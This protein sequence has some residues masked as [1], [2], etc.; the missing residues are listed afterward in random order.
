M[1][2]DGLHCFDEKKCKL[3]DM[4]RWDEFAICYPC[5][6]QLIVMITCGVAGMMVTSVW[7]P[8]LVAASILH[9]LHRPL[10]QLEACGN[11][12]DVQRLIHADLRFEKIAAATQQAKPA[13]PP[14]P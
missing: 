8:T 9:V 12:M 13:P 7:M 1:R 14:S 6:A 5:W 2:K 3:I 4:I 11:E 10:R